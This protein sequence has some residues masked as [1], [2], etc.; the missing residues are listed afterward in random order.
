MAKEFDQD[1]VHINSLSTTFGSNTLS[2]LTINGLFIY[3][4]LNQ[5]V[6]YDYIAKRNRKLNVRNVI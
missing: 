2:Q 4:F 6:Y 5:L 3:F 1:N